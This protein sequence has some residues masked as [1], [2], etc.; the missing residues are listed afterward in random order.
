[1]RP[2]HPGKDHVH[3]VDQMKPPLLSREH[4]VNILL[5]Q[6]FEEVGG[7]SQDITRLSLKASIANDGSQHQGIKFIQL[8][9][10]GLVLVRDSGETITMCKGVINISVPMVPDISLLVQHWKVNP[11]N[12]NPSGSVK[13]GAGP[14]SR[15]WPHSNP[16]DSRR[17]KERLW[18]CVLARGRPS[19]TTKTYTSGCHCKTRFATQVHALR[20][21]SGMRAQAHKEL[22]YT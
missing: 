16:C 14:Q 10:K 9:L 12:A 19:G 20:S 8:L 17:W 18:S 2:R 22:R 21:A 7:F 4:E 5:D 15:I 6:D 1:M 11:L 13:L 3:I